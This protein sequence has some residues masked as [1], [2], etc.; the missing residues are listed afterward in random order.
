MSTSPTSK[1]FCRYICWR[2]CK[3]LEHIG[4]IRTPPKKLEIISPTL[5]WRSTGIFTRLR[6][7]NIWMV[8]YPKFHYLGLNPF[9]LWWNPF[10][11][12]GFPARHL[13][14][15]FV[16][17][18]VHGKSPSKMDGGLVFPLKNLS[19]SVGMMKFPIYKWLFPYIYVVLLGVQSSFP[20]K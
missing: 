3:E 5:G 11:H 12:W 15:P 20:K 16:A 8:S 7:P 19:S 2:L 10:H 17:G 18:W 4:D 14:T 9:Y 6:Y 13:G 1:Y